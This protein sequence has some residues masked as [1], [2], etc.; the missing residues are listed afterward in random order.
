MLNRCR[1]RNAPDDARRRIR[2]PRDV[3][4]GTDNDPAADREHLREGHEHGRVTRGVEPT[5]LRITG[6]ADDRS[7]IGGD[8]RELEHLARP[9]DPFA[10]RVLVREQPLGERLVDDHHFPRRRPV[11]RRKWTSPEKRNPRRVEELG[12]SGTELGAGQRFADRWRFAFRLHVEPGAAAAERYGRTEANVDDAG[13]GRDLA[14]HLLV[15]RLRRRIG[16]RVGE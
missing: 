6:D 10:D 3:A 16:R 11:G 7:P 8:R 2:E 5:V 12:T 13:Q 14:A 9:R 15:A 4:V 1:R